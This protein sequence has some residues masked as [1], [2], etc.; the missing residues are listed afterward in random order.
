ME[1]NKGREPILQAERWRARAADFLDEPEQGN[2]GDQGEFSNADF[3][4]C[5]YHHPRVGHWPGE[6]EAHIHSKLMTTRNI[7]LFR[8]IC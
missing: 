2:E 6:A 1:Q 4:C 5:L 3:W 8:N 7:D